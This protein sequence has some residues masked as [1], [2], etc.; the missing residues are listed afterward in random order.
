MQVVIVFH[1]NLSLWCWVC[2]FLTSNGCLNQLENCTEIG[3]TGAVFL[4]MSI[5][6]CLIAALNNDQS[7]P[8]VRR[9]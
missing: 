6:I 2:F 5:L 3:Y 9:E 4:G 1:S 7:F 8:E